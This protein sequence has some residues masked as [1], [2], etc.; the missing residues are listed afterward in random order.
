[1]LDIKSYLIPAIHS[2]EGTKVM[3]CCVPVSPEDHAGPQA[4]FQSLS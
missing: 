3:F 4:N 1:M 2:K